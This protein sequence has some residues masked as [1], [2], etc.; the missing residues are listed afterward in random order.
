MDNK[1]IKIVGVIML[2]FFIPAVIIV[3]FPDLWAALSVKTR[4]SSVLAPQ[5]YH[6]PVQKE[7][8]SLADN[9]KRPFSYKNFSFSVPWQDKSDTKNSNGILQMSFAS[10]K[11]FFVKEG[12]NTFIAY[13]AK[14]QLGQNIQKRYHKNFTNDF[15]YYKTILYATPASITFST[16]HQDLKIDLDL[17]QLK[18][19]LI[20]E[21]K[22]EYIF[23]HTKSVKGFWS[24]P[25][26]GVDT[27]IIELFPAD[28]T[29]YT[30]STKKMT[31]EEIIFFV[32]SIKF[33]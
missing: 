28:G 15:E 1:L 9:A 31:Q 17:L 30:M 33:P 20:D 4:F 29:H 12:D 32:S 25:A 2:V 8:A 19:Q 27:I 14:T 18:S 22:G 7:I 5:L 6:V 13:L 24:S 10:G 23:F 21:V 11:S 3:F 26:K 16:S